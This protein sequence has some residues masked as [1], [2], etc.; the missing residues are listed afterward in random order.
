VRVVVSV[1]EADAGSVAV[2]Q[3]VRLAVQAVPGPEQSGKVVRTSWALEPGSRT[4]RTEIDLPN[5]KGF[6]RPGM[7]VHAKLTVPLPALWSVPAAA[8]GKVGDESVLY[9]VEA[10][11]AV[12][13]TAQLHKGDG[14][15]ERPLNGWRGTRRGHRRTDVWR[16]RPRA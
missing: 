14:R 13:V 5:E 2:G 10:G 4:L 7:Y 3:D 1:P 8:I 16:V 6:F 11:K 12:R 15:S 9:L